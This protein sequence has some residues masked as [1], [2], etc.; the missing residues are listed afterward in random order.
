MWQEKVFETN[1]NENALRQ[2][3]AFL[4]QK[5]LMRDDFC[6]IACP[7]HLNKSIVLLYRNL[8]EMPPS[9]PQLGPQSLDQEDTL[10]DKWP[11]LV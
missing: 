10:R 3:L 11:P 9:S 8:G 7:E 1:V 6:V 5:R 4:N 2:L